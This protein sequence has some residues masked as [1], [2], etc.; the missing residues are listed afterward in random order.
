MAKEITED[1]FWMVFVDATR[2]NT[3]AKMHF[4]RDDAVNEASRLSKKYPDHKVYILEV[5]GYCTVEPTPVKFTDFS[6]EGRPR[7]RGGPLHTGG[8]N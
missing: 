7:P 5:I 2:H 3:P 4:F 6:V 8:F 1:L